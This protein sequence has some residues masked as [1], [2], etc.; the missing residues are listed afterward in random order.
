MPRFAAVSAPHPMEDGDMVDDWSLGGSL[1]DHTEILPMLLIDGQRSSAIELGDFCESLLMSMQMRLKAD[2]EMSTFRALPS[3]TNNARGIGIVHLSASLG[4]GPSSH[5]SGG[6]AIGGPPSLAH[7]YHHHTDAVPLSLTGAHN[8][9]ATGTTTTPGSSASNTAMA[10]V[11]AMAAAAMASSMASGPSRASDAQRGPVGP[12]GLPVRPRNPLASTSRR[13]FLMYLQGSPS[14]APA[15]ARPSAP[16][17]SPT[18]AMPRTDFAVHHESD[19]GFLQLLSEE[20]QD[21]PTRGSAQQPPH[22]M[23]LAADVVTDGY[24]LMSTAA[25]LVT[26]IGAGTVT[27]EQAAAAGPLVLQAAGFAPSTTG[28]VAVVGPAAAGA[29]PS[30]PEARQQNPSHGA[31][32]GYLEPPPTRAQSGAESSSS[33]RAATTQDDHGRANGTLGF[34]APSPGG[35][36]GTGDGSPVG[37]TASWLAVQ[38]QEQVLQMQQPAQQR[39]PDLQHRPPS[40]GAQPMSMLPASLLLRAGAASAS[41]GSGSGVSG[42]TGAGTGM[43]SGS[44]LGR[45][46]EA[47]SQQAAPR[48]PAPLSPLAP[49][50]STQHSLERGSAAAGRP[51]PAAVAALRGGRGHHRP[52][53]RSSSWYSGSNTGAAPG[54]GKRKLEGPLEL[55]LCRSALELLDGVA[56]LRP[57]LLAGVDNQ[58]NQQPWQWQQGEGGRSLRADSAPMRHVFGGGARDARNVDVVARLTGGGAN[59]GA[60]A[61][62]GLGGWFVGPAEAAAHAWGRRTRSLMLQ[63]RFQGSAVAVKLVAGQ[64]LEPRNRALG[65]ALAS[66]AAA[67]GHASL[68]RIACLRLLLPSSSGAHAAP[69]QPRHAPGQGGGGSGGAAAAATAAAA[70]SVA[71][72]L[73]PL[74]LRPGEGVLAVVMELCTLGSLEPLVCAQQSPF[75]P[76]RAWPPYLA[77]RALLR[78]A[79]EVASALAPLHRYGL[80]HGGVK[81]ANVLLVPAAND[82]RNFVAK[83]ADVGLSVAVIDCG[84]AGAGTGPGGGGSGYPEQRASQG[85]MSTGVSGFTGFT[86]FNTSASV[87]QQQA[88]VALER[89]SLP[90]SQTLPQATHFQRPPSANVPPHPHPY[91]YPSPHQLSPA[92]SPSPGVGTSVISSPAASAGLPPAAGLMLMKADERPFVAPEQREAGR[93]V[94]TPEADVWAFGLLLLSLVTDEAWPPEALALPRQPGD[95]ARATA[96]AWPSG[97]HPHL[98]ELY[99]A[100]TRQA[101][102]QRPSVEQVLAQLRALDN[103]LRSE[104]PK[105]RA[106]AAAGYAAIAAAKAGGGNTALPGLLR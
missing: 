36:G 84:G 26:Q 89:A 74:R 47:L 11:A 87:A 69:E 32:G 70:A 83:L 79:G 67:G 28:A 59:A 73:A 37:R 71:L 92:A 50:L 43:A 86:G 53:T 41:A 2:A 96:P 24:G 9:L 94:A 38:R 90:T 12:L 62:G 6:W 56:D 78:T 25:G 44:P 65:A 60:G 104:R 35:G 57:L 100:C 105:T 51:L 66:A 63:G 54:D 49:I 20:P 91:P 76:S 55:R 82:R 3:T 101:P 99:E 33:G 88:A 42:S 61:D 52:L 85:G 106:A 80:S 22:G 64:G 34:A 7:D 16:S 29:V 1:D 17:P 23:E 97:A 19:V 93:L 40:D 27:D 8:Q 31:L 13:R 58:P 39:T 68:A 81:P 102:E 103:S 10:G 5:T 30:G 75:R 4:P 14:E 15:S 95:E 48:P 21:R 98:R 45:P 18:L 72:T 77:R 46:Q